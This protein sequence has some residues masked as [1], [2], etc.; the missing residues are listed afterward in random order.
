MLNVDMQI[1]TK[2]S[3]KN[4]ILDLKKSIRSDMSKLIDLHIECLEDYD[5]ETAFRC[6]TQL[7]NNW[8]TLRSANSL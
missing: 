5:L 7:V 4:Q 2:L 3:E 6:L 8:K 1:V